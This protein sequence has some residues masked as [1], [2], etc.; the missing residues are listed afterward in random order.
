MPIVSIFG[1]NQILAHE[2]GYRE[3]IQVGSLLAGAG[4]VVATGGYAGVMEAASRGAREAGGRTI[5]VIT[6][7]F[8]DRSN[9]PNPWL[10]EVVTFPTL[11]QRLHHLVTFSDALVAL[12]GG[13]GTLSEVALA[14]SLMQV[15]EM[16]CKP[17]VLVGP[18]WR[19]VIESYQRESTIRDHDLSL[20]AF[21][22][23]PPDVLP[24]LR[25][26]R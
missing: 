4:Y 11:F 9:S 8:A 18:A 7:A 23:A 22:D 20:L 12:R 1:G 6:S 5:G 17:F 25:G 14:W 10:D 19:R 15:R 26:T 13:V 2:A 24:F 3:A 21:A 16:P